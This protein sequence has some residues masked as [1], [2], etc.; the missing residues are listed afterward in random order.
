[1][2]KKEI[3]PFAGNEVDVAWNKQLC[4]HIGECGQATGDLF[5][6]GRQPWCQPDQVASADVA[7]VCERCPSGAL[8]Y[9]F[10]SSDKTESADTENTVQ[11]VYNGP[12]FV[13]GDLSI[14]AVPASLTGVKYRAALCRCGQSK[15]KPFCDNSHEKINFRDY[16]AVGE[17]GEALKESGGVLTI[18]PAKDGPLLLSGNV[19]IKAGSGRAAW[20]GDNVALCRCGA[21]KNKPFCDGSH[22]QAG[23]RSH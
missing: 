21:S 4:I 5:V 15:N 1:M 16:G 9:T 14:D 22:K 19:T 12:Y 11:V 18:K 13:R 23:F 8:T 2:S 10:K 17:R 7:E 3:Y 6:K 20:Q